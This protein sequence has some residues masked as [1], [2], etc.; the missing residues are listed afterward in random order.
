MH[1]L[2]T[3]ILHED[4]YMEIREWKIIKAN[5]PEEYLKEELEYAKQHY[6]PEHYEIPKEGDK[7]DRIQPGWSTDTG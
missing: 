3:V 6:H 2:K 1:P 7:H 5:L 4:I